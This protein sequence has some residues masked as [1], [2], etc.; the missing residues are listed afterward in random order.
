ML[1]GFMKGSDEGKRS[2]ARHCAQVRALSCRAGEDHAG[3]CGGKALRVLPHGEQS[4]P[5]HACLQG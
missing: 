3:A 2:Q 5:E 4:L 1:L